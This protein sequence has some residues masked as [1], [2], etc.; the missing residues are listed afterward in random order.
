MTTHYSSNRVR[1][2]LYDAS[3]GPTVTWG[4]W[5]VSVDLF[6]DW[7]IFML[8]S[9]EHRCGHDLRCEVVHSERKRFAEHTQTR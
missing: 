6:R 9:H 3:G 1:Q 5:G 2:Q 7:H 4:P 8:P